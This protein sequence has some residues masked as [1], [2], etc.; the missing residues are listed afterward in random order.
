VNTTQNSSFQLLLAERGSKAVE[1]LLNKIRTE[2]PIYWAK[3]PHY[4][5]LLESVQTKV[6]A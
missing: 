2:Y 3:R 5:E 4:K 1:I 6:G